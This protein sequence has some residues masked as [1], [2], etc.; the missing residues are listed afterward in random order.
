MIKHNHIIATAMA[1]ACAATALASSPAPYGEI[2]DAYPPG[3]VLEDINM[4]T[5]EDGD[6]AYKVTANEKYG[7]QWLV[8]VAYSYWHTNGA[9]SNNHNN[10]MLLHTILTQRIIENKSNG[11][12]W[13]RFE[14]SGSWGLDARSA[15][16]DKQFTDSVGETS[17]MHADIYGPHDAV[18][19][20]LSLMQYFNSNRACV[21]AGLV[22]MTN[23][24]DCVGPANDSFH[25]FTNN[26]FVN[27]TVLALPDAN[28]G[29]IVQFEIDEESYAMLG[30]SRETCTYGDNPFQSGSSY[31]IVG[32]YGRNN[33]LD[34]DATVRITPFFRQVE[35]AGKNRKNAGIAASIEYAP[36]DELTLFAR[37]GVAAK[38]DLGAAFDFSCGATFQGI[39]G[40]EDDHVGLALG[41]FKGTNHAD[42]PTTHNREYVL[43][44]MYSYQIN[45]YWKLVPHLQYIKDPA[46]SSESDAVIMGVQAV[47]SF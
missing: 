45:D 14:L 41:V 20:E 46:Y 5:P 21:I 7:T 43:E 10:Y 2:L 31:M 39:P 23:Y 27:S 19:P 42:E 35:E 15:A 34:G 11:G 13:L 32:E 9:A 6:P 30:F 26:A 38:Q 17:W 44:A 16:A 3:A 36:C 24:F 40:R 12:T 33:I 22:N 4:Y 1:A 18:I 29:A 8:D 37:S 28:L 25:S 47:F